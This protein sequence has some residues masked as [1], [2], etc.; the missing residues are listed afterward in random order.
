MGDDKVRKSNEEFADLFNGVKEMVD[1]AYDATRRKHGVEN[2]DIAL[3]TFFKSN[4]V[5]Y[6]TSDDNARSNMEELLGRPFE[7]LQLLLDYSMSSFILNDMQCDITYGELINYAT[8]YK[9]K[10]DYS[11]KI[12]VKVVALAAASNPYWAIELVCSNHQLEEGLIDN[13]IQERYVLERRDELDSTNQPRLIRFPDTEE[14]FFMNKD[15]LNIAIQNMNQEKML[16]EY[17]PPTRRNGAT[18]M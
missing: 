16:G 1:N 2:A 7:F 8:E 4:I 9:D 13:F 15:R 10:L 14:R 11:D 3:T 5:S 17:I 18:K 6:F 12:P